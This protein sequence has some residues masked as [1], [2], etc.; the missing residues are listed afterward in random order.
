MVD[1]DHAYTVAEAKLFGKLVEEFDIFGTKN[2]CLLQ[3]IGG[4]ELREALDIP[5]ATGE[6]EYLRWGFKI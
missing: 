2:L 1:A 5:I 4:R 6:N 3:I